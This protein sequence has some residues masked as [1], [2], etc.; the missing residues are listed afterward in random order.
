MSEPE[1]KHD[2]TEWA[3][4]EEQHESGDGERPD[5]RAKGVGSMVVQN[6]DIQGHV[7]LADWDDWYPNQRVTDYSEDLPGITLLIESSAGSYHLWNLTVRGQDTTAL[8]LLKL[9]SDPMRTMIGYRWRPT[10]WVNRIGPKQYADHSDKSGEYKPSPKLVSIQYNPTTRPQSKCHWSIAKGFIEGMPQE[11]P[12]W[13]VEWFTG[14][15]KVE[16]YGAYT[17]EQKRRWNDG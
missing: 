1:K 12:G 14:T 9:K 2:I 15:T 4:E 11:T 3:D 6:D 5:T 10:R 7:L 16:S 17:D 8:E 13:E